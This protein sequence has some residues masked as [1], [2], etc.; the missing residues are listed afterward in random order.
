MSRILSILSIALVTLLHGGACFAQA[1]VAELTTQ[2]AKKL[3]KEELQKLHAGGVTQKGTTRN[4]ADYTQQN[5][6]DGSVSGNAQS[7]RGSAGLYG[8]WKI[9][10]SGKLCLD[11]KTTSGG[12]LQSC[13]FVWTLGD[14][15]FSTLEDTAATDARPIQFIK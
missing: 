15:Y 6:P 13:F 5:K 2:G 8:T 9:E 4:G 14:K 7:T 12:S 10:D 11:L 1:T 3:S